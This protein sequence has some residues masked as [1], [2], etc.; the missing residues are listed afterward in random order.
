MDQL[1][2]VL[3]VLFLAFTIE[4]IVLGWVSAGYLQTYFCQ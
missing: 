4:V 1:E 3:S 2:Q